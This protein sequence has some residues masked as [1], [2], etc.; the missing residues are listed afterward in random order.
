VKRFL[1]LVIILVIGL[2]LVSFGQQLVNIFPQEANVKYGGTL[3]LVMPWGPLTF[4]LNPFLPAGV[5]LGIIPELYESLFYIN[6][7]NGNTTPLLGTNYKWEDN[8]L[9][10][11]VSVRQGVKWSDGTPFTAQDVAF[12]I[13]YIK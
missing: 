1:V 7:L 5:R 2:S 3:K 10:L 11:V 4:N 12:T 6:S 13:N 9:K 8:N